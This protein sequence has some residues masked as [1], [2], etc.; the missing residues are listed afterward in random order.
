[1]TVIRASLRILNSDVDFADFLYTNASLGSGYKFF[2]PRNVDVCTFKLTIT[3]TCD[4]CNDIQFYVQAHSLP[5]AKNYLHSSV[6]NSSQTGDTVIEFYPHENSWHYVDLKFFEQITND[7]SQKANSMNASSPSP[8]MLNDS[9]VQHVEY[10]IMIE[11]L[12]NNINEQN[13]DESEKFE[14]TDKDRSNDYIK[15]VPLMPKSRNFD[16]S[17]LLRQTYREFFMYDYDLVP[18][19]NGTQPVSINLTAGIPSLMKFDIGDVYDIG[20]TLSFAIAMKYDIS[21]GLIES[22]PT[23][24]TTIDLNGEG[25]IAEKLVAEDTKRSNQTVIVCMR[26]NEP[27]IPTWPDKCTY[28]RHIFPANSVINNTDGETGTSVSLE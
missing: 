11:F 12:Y 27:G 16:E 28:G 10:S 8:S 21:G 19:A 1:M 18:D 20:G 15:Y 7:A 6:I 9:A 4:A 23:T 17:P 25:A 2:V 14:T 24:S 22:V 5:T 3:K 13:G 26:L